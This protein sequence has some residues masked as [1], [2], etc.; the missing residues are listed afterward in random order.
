MLLVLGTLSRNVCAFVLPPNLTNL[1]RT[2]MLVNI[3]L[4]VYVVVDP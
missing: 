2:Q 4:D 1:K 3:R